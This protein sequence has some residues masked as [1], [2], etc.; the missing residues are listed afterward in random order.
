MHAPCT[1]LYSP[2]ESRSNVVE[3]LSLLL[4]LSWQFREMMMTVRLLCI[5]LFSMWLSCFR[6]MFSLWFLCSNFSSWLLCFIFLCD[7]MTLT[8]IQWYI[9]IY[10]HHS[11][12]VDDKFFMQR[13]RGAC[14]GSVSYDLQ[15]WR[16]D[17]HS[18]LI[19]LWETTA[20]PVLLWEHW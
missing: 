3:G 10:V 11:D 19:M 14:H 4:Q 9:Y 12:D 15:Q 1:K 8:V 17:T 16:S 18:K 20:V 13:P 7:L 5:N 2:I 6:Q